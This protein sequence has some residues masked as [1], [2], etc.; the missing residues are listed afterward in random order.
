MRVVL[1]NASLRPPS[2]DQIYQPLGIAYLAAVLEQS[3]IN[4]FLVD[5][6]F[7]FSIDETVEEIAHLHPDIIGISVVSHYAN[8]A[9]EMIRKI[10]AVAQEAPIIAGGHHCTACHDQFLQQTPE[11]SAVV[12]GEGESII[13]ELAKRLHHGESLAGIQSITYRNGKDI[14]VNPQG[15]PIENLDSLPLPAR[16]LLSPLKI[17]G[18]QGT[19]VSSRGCPY[20]CRFCTVH[21]AYGEI[22]TSKWRA[23]N[24]IKVVDE[25]EILKK[26]GAEVIEFVDDNFLLSMERAKR[27][28]EEIIS[29]NFDVPYRIETRSDLVIKAKDILP[30]LRRSGCIKVRIGAESGSEKVLK[31]YNKGITPEESSKAISLLREAN[32]EAMVDWIMFDAETTLEELKDSLKFIEKN[33]LT[34]HSKIFRTWLFPVPGSEIFNDYVKEQRLV[35]NEN[36]EYSYRIA[37]PKARFVFTTFF[38]FLFN[39]HS[40][41]RVI[42]DFI[43][44]CIWKTMREPSFNSNKKEIVSNLK[45]LS[46]KMRKINYEIF[47]KAVQATELS[48]TENNMKSQILRCG[49][50][51]LSNYME[52]LELILMKKEDDRLLDIL[53]KIEAG[54]NIE[55][56][57]YHLLSSDKNGL[58]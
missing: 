13:T 39:N 5:S 29:R 42:L 40:K 30:L 8:L 9:R 31:R 38:T 4:V 51:L 20:N 50:D 7:H 14:V 33:K 48:R 56:L 1:T 28:A 26:M 23:R 43:K 54:K 16:H 2:V 11:L 12:R 6:Q 22:H 45:I 34:H 53:E 49:K 19:I 18:G 47:K 36:G 27:I 46:F 17:Y 15:P 32:I 24:P 25:M 57:I 10:H 3:G 58:V 41:C 37:E 52:Q 44:Y 55:P 35:Q 21:L